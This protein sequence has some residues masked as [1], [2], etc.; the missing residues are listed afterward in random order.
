MKVLPLILVQIL[1]C[2]ILIAI[3][4]AKDNLPQI[5]KINESKQELLNC[6][7]CGYKQMHPTIKIASAPEYVFLLVLGL[8]I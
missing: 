1:L 7:H 4:K 8:L 2:V 3:R 5:L 6:E